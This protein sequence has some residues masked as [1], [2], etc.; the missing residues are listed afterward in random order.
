MSLKPHTNPDSLEILQ[1]GPRE[2]L[3]K[4]GAAIDGL[5]GKEPYFSAVLIFSKTDDFGKTETETMIILN[6][7]H[8]SAVRN[9]SIDIS[10]YIERLATR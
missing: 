10:Q 2:R 9:A 6:Q 8:F 1:E 7:M 4:M 5:K 3:E